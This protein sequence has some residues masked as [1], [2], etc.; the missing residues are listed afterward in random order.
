M[1]LRS[2]R[3]LSFIE[4]MCIYNKD[5]VEE[6]WMPTVI[7]IGSWITM[8]TSKKRKINEQ[9]S[10]FIIAWKGRVKKFR[11]ER[12]KKMVLI[13]HVFMHKDVF[14]Q[15]SSTLPRHKP[16]CK[17]YCKSSLKL[18]GLFLKHKRIVFDIVC[19]HSQMCILPTL[20]NGKI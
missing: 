13:Q 8:H 16:K 17:Y 12:G 9:S 14:T 6:I 20:K 18:V 11:F 3:P 15:P 19:T 7:K 5:D 1:A 2:K 10:H 4:S